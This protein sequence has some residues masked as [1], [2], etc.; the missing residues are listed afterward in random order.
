MT[1][2]EFGLPAEGL[3]RIRAVLSR[4]AHIDQA[5]LY[6]SRAMGRERPGS[7]IDLTLT[8]SRLEQADIDRLNWQLDDLLLPWQFDLSIYQHIDNPELRA[9]I[10]RVGKVLY[11]KPK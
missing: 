7:D 9:H 1:D 2:T 5:I 3:S 11:Q 6:G 4:C 10:D 8:G